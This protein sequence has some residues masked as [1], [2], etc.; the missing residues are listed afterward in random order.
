VRER[1]GLDAGRTE[2]PIVDRE[3]I[4]WERVLEVDRDEGRVAVR[5]ATP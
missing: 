5:R 2:K 3:L 4:E 1:L